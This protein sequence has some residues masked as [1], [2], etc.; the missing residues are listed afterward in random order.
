MTVCCPWCGRPFRLRTSGGTDQRFCSA[1]CRTAFWTAARRWV[2]RAF[3]AGLLSTDVL[4]SPQNKL[5]PVAN[6]PYLEKAT[7]TAPGDDRCE[8][9]LP[10]G[11]DATLPKRGPRGL[12]NSRHAE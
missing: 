12:Y 2:M 3:Q 10:D 9:G 4:K 11:I 8:Y 6:G 5:S 1:V 7:N